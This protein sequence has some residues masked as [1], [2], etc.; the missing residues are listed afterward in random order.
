MNLPRLAVERPVAAL[1]ALISVLVI[2]GIALARIPLAFLPTVD[3]PF[4]GIQIPYP[5]SNPTQI[6]RD[7]TK[8]VEE[9]LATLKGVRKMSS[10]STADSAEFNLEFTWG[11]EI[12]ILRMQVGE[13]MDQI[14]PSLPPEIGEIQIFSFNTNDIPVVEARIAAE[15]VDL[16]QN[17][18]LLESRIANRIRR[19]PGVA[20]VDMDGVA[21]REIFI[22]L[23]LD[24]VKEHSIDV[25]SL[26]QRLQGSS[27]NLVLGQ[28]THQGLRYTARALGSFESVEAIRNLPVNE[29]GLRLSEIAEIRYE[30]PVIAYGRH[31]D[32]K[33]AVA[34]RVFKE[35]TAATVEVARAVMKVIRE[36][37]D[38]DP[39]LRG[40]QVLVWN[41]QARE[42]TSGINGLKTSGAIGALLA[43]LVLYFFLRRVDSTLIISFSI[44]FS[45]LA[46]VG[47]LYFLGKNLNVLSM[48]GLMLGVGMLV[49]NGV[50]L[51]ESID[52][53]HRTEPDT[54]KAALQGTRDV[55][56]AV[57]S[58]T[59][60][61][62][63][64]FLPLAVGASTELTTWL[65]EVGKAISIALACS[66]LC[67]LTLIPL[68]SA[69]LLR[70]KEI[71]PPRSSVWLEDRYVRIL[72]W[73]LRRKGWTFLIVTAALVLGFLPF[74]TPLLDTSMF[75]ASIN[76]RL[77]LDYEFS[78][79]A[80]K[81][82]A[83][84]AVNQVEEYLNAHREEL[85]I[86][87]VYSFYTENRAGTTMTLT[88]ENLSDPEIR[89]LRK[90]IR[91]NLPEIP[92]ARVVS[93]EEADE[94]GSSTFFA[95]KFF[96]QDSGILQ[97]LAREAE[98]R[99]ETVKGVTDISTSLNR[100]RQ[101]VQVVIDRSK[102]LRRGL[103]AQDLSDI[104]RFTLG[105]MRLQRFNAGNREVETWLA[106][107]LKDREN[108]EDLKSI[109]ILPASGRPIQLADIASFQVVRRAQEIE[110]ENRKVRFAVRA[111]YE[112]DTWPQAQKEITGLVDSLDLP[113]GYSW[114]WNDRILEKAE[115]DQQMLINFVLALL[116]VYIVMASLFESLVQPFAILFS[117][118]FALVGAT[119][120]LTVTGTPFNLMSWIGLLILM[121]IVVNNGIVLLDHLNHLRRAGIPRDEAILRTGRERLRPILMTATTTIVGLIP[122]AVG[123]S[124]LGGW[125]YYYPLART[126]IGGLISSTILT[127]VV[128][129]YVLIGVEETAAWARRV[130]SASA[131]RGGTRPEVAGARAGALQA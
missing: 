104:F 99:L 21:P 56:L 131:R 128:L 45:L 20:R 77:F 52:R 120:L 93:R 40:V 17:F 39:L 110:R 57:A 58:S 129:P 3:A 35:S 49:D 81:S 30:E 34:V 15:G 44:P 96:G 114:S 11:Q 59:L 116:L 75:S 13:K 121:G 74:F 48:M 71:P 95:V 2:G 86:K 70:R 50:V 10:T 97:K 107:R 83:E 101:E 36:D 109:Q 113:S 72:G 108:L 67:S 62:I 125:C 18:D 47:T 51:L 78:D 31:L 66:L 119:W 98:R 37:I 24:R 91:K 111:T 16:S 127:L 23:I 112:G 65:G 76:R 69:H 55:S 32:G 84:R 118:P 28:V 94:G 105:G 115:E 90:K 102:A 68:M 82:D 42:I 9:I 14:K 46:T 19:V 117:I 122:L 88:N 6:E 85:L 60:T 124:G 27:G 106:L 92:G 33:Y 26:I 8:P 130:W 38:Q 73:T 53:K 5:N 41:D 61:T 4:I 64:V 87:S 43:V 22:D 54:R 29:S 103:S 25:G 79:F 100:G 80:Y 7:I 1:M 123:N 126:V 63:I 12:D 89:E